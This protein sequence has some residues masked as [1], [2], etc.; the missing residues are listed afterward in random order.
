[1]EKSEKI[2]VFAIV[3]NLALLG[4][5]YAFAMLSH[6]IALK[7][8]ALHSLSDV[9]ASLMVFGGLML[10]KRK[11]K[12]FPYG[13]YKVE[14]LVSIIV[15][16]VIFFAGYEIVTEALKSGAEHKLENVPITLISVLFVIGITFAFSRY[17][18]KVGKEINSPSLIADAQ[19]IRV[20]MFA[21][22]VV[23]VGLLSN[24][25][26]FNLDRIA[27]FIIAIFIAWAGG[28]I[29]LNAIRVL[30]DASLDYETLSQT[31]KIINSE[32][33]VAEIKNLTGRNSGR[34]KFIEADIVLK[35]HDFDKAHFV[36]NRI[37]TNIKEEIKNVDHVL[38]HY[39]PTQKENFIYAM[40]IED[41]EGRRISAHFGEALHFIL[42]TVRAKD[43]TFVS[44]EIIENPF[45]HVERGKG[46]L[47]AEF[48]IK[49]AI[50]VVITK[51]SFEGK[52][53]AYVFSDSAVEVLQAED[54]EVKRTLESLGVVFANTEEDGKNEL[55]SH[56]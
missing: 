23:L 39:E 16:L 12:K 42:V 30:L 11:S 15:A 54:D 24:L 21:G 44:Q 25:V 8:E 26:G 38:I 36:A 2:A 17:E 18:L 46:I 55:N 48:L 33:Q 53:P 52:G 7:A 4:I 13:L 20:D 6:S 22:A 37:E 51:E 41:A 45:T 1:M 49:R 31:E 29:L 34:Y 40:P 50:D 28:E 56:A 5:K 43:K 10:A 35:T 3:V 9:V 32:P 14:N 27:A 47:V 19:H